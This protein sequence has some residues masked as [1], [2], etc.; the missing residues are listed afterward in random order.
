MVFSLKSNNPGTGVGDKLPSKFRGK[1]ERLCV[2]AVSVMKLEQQVNNLAN[3]QG[4]KIRQ[5]SRV[6]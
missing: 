4:K 6:F 5:L 3:R 2:C 1:E